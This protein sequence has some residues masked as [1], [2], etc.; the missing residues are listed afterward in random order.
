MARYSFLLFLFSLMHLQPLVRSGDGETLLA[1]KSWIDPSNS[2]QWRGSDFCKWQGVKECMRGRV[3]KLVL[4]HLNLNGTLDE[5]S[6]AQLDQL[7]VLS[8]K[9]NSLSGQIPDLSGLI[10]LKSL[11]L[12]NNNF[13]GDFPSSLSGLHRLKVIILAGN[14]ISGQ[15]PASLLKLQRLY[16][17]YLQDN[18]LTGEIPPLNQT[19]LRF[20]NVSNNQLSGEIP[21]TPAVVRFN[22][23][24]F[25][26]NL[27]LCGEQVNSPCPRS[28]AISPD[29]GGGVLLIC[30]IL[31]CVS[32]RR[33]RR[34]T[35]EGR[36]KGKAV[37]AVGSPEA[38]NGGFVEGVGGDAGEG[39]DG[40]HVQGGDGVWV[41]SDREEAQGRQIPPAG[42]VQGTDGASR[43]AE[44]PQFGASPCL[45]PGQGGTPPRIRLLPQRQS[46]LPHSWIKN[47]RWWKASSLDILPKNWRG[48]G[49]WVAL[50]PPEPWPNPWELEIIQCPV[51]I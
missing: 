37:G 23:S 27:E 14:Q 50:Y 25:S 13:S 26:N 12:N 20:F 45:L 2:L 24:S 38:A 41:Y 30:L 36:S 40:K 34:K 4:E 9:E 47:F 31:L 22:Q 46:L 8:F 42:G 19:S 11:F 6:L 28:P 3:T 51:R 1:L 33:M 15:I 49:Y 5:K 17:L 16:I 18:R 44:A 7:R 43:E 10:N 35:V 21:L 29:V 32:Y 39:D 48:L